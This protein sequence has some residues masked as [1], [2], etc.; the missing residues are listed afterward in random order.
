MASRRRRGSGRHDPIPDRIYDRISTSRRPVLL[1]LG[2]VSLLILCV[3]GVFG[4]Q[5]VKAKDALQVAASEAKQLQAQVSVGDVDSA[6]GTLRRLQASTKAAQSHTDGPLWDLGGHAPLL[7][8]SVAAVQTIS[9]VLHDLSLAGLQPIVDAADSIDSRA[10]SPRDGRINIKAIA[11]LAPAII[12]ADRSLSASK[13]E[14]AAVSADDVVGPLKAPV[15][16]LKAKLATA[17]R[18]ASSGATAAQI[19]PGMLGGSDSRSYLLV[20]QNNAEVRSTGGLPGAFA[21]V[22]AE[23]GKIGLTDQG[24]GSD[25]GYFDKPAVK[26]TKDENNLYTTLMASFWSDTNFTPDFP[27]T[28]QIMRAMY[29]KRFDKTVDGVISVD[30]IALSYIL[31]ATGPVKLAKGGPLTS[32][33]AVDVLL[34]RVYLKFPDDNT[35]QDAFFADAAARVFKAVASGKGEPQSVLTQMSKAT[36]ENRMLI[37]SHDPAEQK[38]LARTR[39]AGGLP[40]DS[41]STPH[42]GVYLNDSTATKLEY[43]LK[44]K[45]TMHSE[46][47][48]TDKVQTLSVTTVLTSTVPKGA[49]G[50]P[51]TIL[52][53]SSGAENGAM[54]LNVRIYAPY[55]GL[56]NEVSVDDELQTVLSAVHKKRNVT[57][58]PVR[59]KPG[60][61]VTI[62]TILLTGQHQ[63]RNPVLSVTPTV[64]KTPNNLSIANACKR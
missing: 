25:F 23:N 14:L 58:V 19:M 24:A 57:I 17:Q 50:L 38:V 12:T 49:K 62:R 3:L 42:V 36:E 28:G 15:Q 20:V 45:T 21:V 59:L 10:F 63:P 29:K 53:P 18:A 31:K 6:Q 33:N 60:Q 22:K 55:G 44:H 7:G 54:R 30:P 40:S 11:D 47:C 41:G 46:S 52:G 16:D 37:W 1:A 2:S 39:I 61:T 51:K 32:K 43:Y 34:N 5:A 56:V 64:S 27:R 26:L 48:T 35:A 9:R 13:K 8:D 4:Y